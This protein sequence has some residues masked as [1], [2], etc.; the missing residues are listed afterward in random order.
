MGPEA[1][2][3]RYGRCGRDVVVYVFN[4][5]GLYTYSPAD[6]EYIVTVPLFDKVQV[7]LGDGNRWTIRH[8]GQGRKITGITCGG[9]PSTV[10]SCRTMR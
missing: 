4:A 7:A 3:V 10:G 1:G 5:I 9:K 6:P 2:A 8:D